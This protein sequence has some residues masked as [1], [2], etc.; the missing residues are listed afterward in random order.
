[1]ALRSTAARP[2]RCAGG[3]ALLVAG[4]LAATAMRTYLVDQVDM[5]LRAF[6]RE[7]RQPATGQ[8]SGQSPLSSDLFIQ[9]ADNTG[10]VVDQ[11]S[12]LR[13][14]QRPGLPVMTRRRCATNG[15]VHRDGW[16]VLVGPPPPA[17]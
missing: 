17:P 9:V 7:F 16:R 5:A 3:L 8:P 11:L 12:N 6:A 1:M 4:V 2:D 13:A 14:A 15:A 10:T